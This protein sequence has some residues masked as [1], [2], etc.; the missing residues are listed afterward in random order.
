MKN[1]M[2]MFLAA[3]AMLVVWADDVH[4]SDT[5]VGWTYYINGIVEGA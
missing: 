4:D 5:G 3:A 1:L 2:A